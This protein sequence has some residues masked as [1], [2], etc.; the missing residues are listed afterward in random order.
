[1]L[2]RVIRG[3]VMGG[4]L[5]AGIAFLAGMMTSTIETRVAVY[6]TPGTGKVQ[7]LKTFALEGDVPI[8]SL[9]IRA[10]EIIQVDT[11]CPRE[12]CHQLDVTMYHLQRF[13]VRLLRFRR[14]T[15]VPSFGIALRDQGLRTLRSIKAL[16]DLCSGCREV[17][18]L[19]RISGE[20]RDLV[21]TAT[22]AVEKY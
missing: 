1:M 21:T 17:E 16:E 20:L 4:G 10:R 6:R 7:E 12:A 8:A 13:F 19:L 15:E 22:L 9:L 2:T 11:S 5:G 14:H 18:Y 3:A